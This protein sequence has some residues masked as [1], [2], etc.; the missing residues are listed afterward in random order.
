[1]ESGGLGSGSLT[2]GVEGRERG[3]ETFEDLG[4]RKGNPKITLTTKLELTIIWRSRFFPGVSGNRSVLDKI[5]EEI[6]SE[7]T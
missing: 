7:T 4:R 5:K 3:L 6:M 1:M 2:F